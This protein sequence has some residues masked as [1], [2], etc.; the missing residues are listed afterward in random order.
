MS[1]YSV[2][3]MNISREIVLELRKILLKVEEDLH[4][5]KLDEL[6]L[7]GDALELQIAR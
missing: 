4:Q 2:G 3:Q 6:R 7:T 5:N 1:G